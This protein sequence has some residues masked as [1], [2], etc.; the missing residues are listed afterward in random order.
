MRRAI[1]IGPGAAGEMDII[2]VV[3]KTSARENR[4]ATDIESL[5]QG[6]AGLALPENEKQDAKMK[7]MEFLTTPAG[8]ALLGDAVPRLRSMMG[9]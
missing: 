2:T 1:T 3:E 9:F 6:I 5:I 4:F 7:V 8:S